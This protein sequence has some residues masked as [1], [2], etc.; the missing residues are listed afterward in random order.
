LKTSLV[1]IGILPVVTL[2]HI[3]ILPVVTCVQ[4]VFTIII[5]VSVTGLWRHPTIV[6]FRVNFIL[7]T[8][9][10]LV[11]DFARMQPRRLKLSNIIDSDDTF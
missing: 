9:R 10:P 4:L 6:L 2:V 3:G 1:Y 8:L 7:P 11:T 5:L